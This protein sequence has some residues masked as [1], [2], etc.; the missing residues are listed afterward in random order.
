MTAPK[1]QPLSN[2]EQRHVT[3]NLCE[4]CDSTLGFLDC[5]ITEMKSLV[6]P[7]ERNEMK[8]MIAEYRE[9]SVALRAA[10]TD[11][12]AAIQQADGGNA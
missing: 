1:Y 11:F 12:Q 8:G 9:V 7:W 10:L 2:E 3:Q 6:M 5:Q 4:A